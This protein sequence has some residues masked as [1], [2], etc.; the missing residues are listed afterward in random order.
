[1]NIN[2]H[3]NATTVPQNRR[4]F[5]ES[6]RPVAAL[7][8]AH[9]VSKT[10]VRRWRNRRGKGVQDRP[11]TR[12]NLGAAITGHVEDIVLLLRKGLNLSSRHIHEV[13][14]CGGICLL[15]TSPSPRDATLSRMP[16]SA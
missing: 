12:H 9:S 2:L 7:A 15:Y 8:Q 13:L 14:R 1:M 3:Q 6:K 16:S 4:R 5:Q 11:S 10:T